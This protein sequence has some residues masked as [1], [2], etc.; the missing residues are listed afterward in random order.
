MSEL[1]LSET[2]KPEIIDY[3]KE[4]RP[5]PKE[6]IYKLYQDDADGEILLTGI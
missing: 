2:E 1:N 4:G 5:L 3:I 6:Y